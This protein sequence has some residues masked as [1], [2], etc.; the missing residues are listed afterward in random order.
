[1]SSEDFLQENGFGY[2]SKE[3]LKDLIEKLDKFREPDI[4]KLIKDSFFRGIE[5]QGWK[6]PSAESCWA[7][8]NSE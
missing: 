8:Y 3:T 7:K 2:L 5:I 4:A 1:M 6:V